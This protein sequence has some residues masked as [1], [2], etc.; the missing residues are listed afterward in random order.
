[1]AKL[2]LLILP[3]ALALALALTSCSPDAPPPSNPQAAA[4]A[5]DPAA[6]PAAAEQPAPAR[7]V[8][9]LGKYFWR[10][11]N[12]VNAAGDQI[13]PL[14]VNRDKP[15]QL[16]FADGRLQVSNTCNAMSG[17]YRITASELEVA[18]LAAT[19]RAC[20]DPQ[21]MALDREVGDRLQGRLGY[22]LDAGIPKLVLTTAGGDVLTFS[23]HPTPETEYGGPGSTV[24]LQVDA[25]S[26]PCPHPLMKDKHCLQVR[27]VRFDDAGRM[28][29][30]DEQWHHSYDGIQGY[31]HADG[32][33]EVVRVKRYNRRNVPADANSQVDI[34]DMVV[35]SE[36][37]EPEAAPPSPAPG[38]DINPPSGT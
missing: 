25:H 4:S 9:T 18:A 14:L 28:T 2:R 8:Q 36:V 3:L 10:L 11:G 23:G 17:G 16:A 5:S 1:M 34:L 22:Q 13:K 30:V 31:E 38:D 21:V 12:A 27:E 29:V 37:V 19:Q 6:A 20:I 15:V 24:F 35:Q 33:R 7:T 26:K 32:V